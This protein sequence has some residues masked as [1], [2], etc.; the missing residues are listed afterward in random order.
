MPNDIPKSK[1][2]SSLFSSNTKGNDRQLV[3]RLQNI[4]DLILQSV[5]EGIFGLDKNGNAIFANP[6][7]LSLFGYSYNELHG[8]HMHTLTHYQHKDGTPYKVEDCPIY[9]AIH[10]GKKI[11]GGEE[12]FFTKKGKCFPV[13]FTSTP[14]IEQGEIIG[15]VVSF[16]DKS[17]ILKKEEAVVRLNTE[18]TRSNKD[19]QDFASVAS[20][21]LQEPLRKILAFS[22]RLVQKYQTNLPGE[23]QDYLTRIDKAAVRMQT[24][25][26]DLL[27]F[28]RVTTKQ[29]PYQEIS[30]NTLIGEVLEDL[31]VVIEQTKAKVTVTQLPSIQA[32]PLQ[33]RQLFQNI[34]GNALKFH[35]PSRSPEIAISLK[36]P[37]TNKTTCTILIKD[38]GIGFD[39]KYLDK[40]FTVFQ[41]LHTSQE[42]S[43]TGVGLAVCR[44]IVERHHGSITGASIVGKGSTFIITLPLKQPQDDILARS[45]HKTKKRNH[46]RDLIRPLHRYQQKEVNVYEPASTNHHRFS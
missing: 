7:A 8:K 2:L 16:S 22:Y 36:T 44:R 5:G 34:L 32:D 19:L 26:N 18:L 9:Q 3:S 24:L 13:T 38:N 15:A 41:R 12:W 46:K 6:S 35:S 42:Y 30:L 45:V 43:G 39:E 14:L 10:K 21:D 11:T 25:I 17:E 20:H 27:T 28:S 37:K 31:E 40:I 29:N 23:A 1:I 4:N 33:M